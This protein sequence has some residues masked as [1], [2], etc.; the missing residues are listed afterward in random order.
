MDLNIEISGH[1]VD[2]LVLALEE[3]K[4]R[5]E[6]GFT[7]GMDGNDTGSYRF[8]V[9]GSPIEFYVVGPEGMDED[10]Y[11]ENPD[12]FQVHDNYDEAQSAYLDSED[13]KAALYGVFE[14]SHSLTMIR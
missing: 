9:T 10:A 7:E 11:R 2:E 1:A 4:K 14:D 5:V 8:T 13:P 6:Q 3:V 12:Q